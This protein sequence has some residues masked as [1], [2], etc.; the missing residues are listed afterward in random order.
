MAD[1][2]TF[3]PITGQFDVT[4]DTSGLL[5]L[6]QTTPQT[7]ENG[8]PIFDKGLIIKAGERIYFDG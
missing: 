3:N 2:I 4:A 5:K 6:D 7:I 8:T 1:K